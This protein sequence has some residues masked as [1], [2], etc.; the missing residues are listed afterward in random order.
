M[1]RLTAGVTVVPAVELLLD[2]FGSPTLEETVAVLLIVPPADGAVTVMVIFGAAPTARLDRVQ[3]I[4]PEPFTQFHP[5]PLA[6]TKPTPAGRVSRTDT[7][8]AV[9]GPLLFTLRV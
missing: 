2:E 5:V 9:L 8:E 3:V 6:L 7:L 4:T 1:D